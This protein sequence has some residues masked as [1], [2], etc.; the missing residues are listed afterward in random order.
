[1]HWET[2][3]TMG[4]A[5]SWWSDTKPTVSLRY[6][7]TC[8]HKL[9]EIWRGFLLVQNKV[10]SKNGIQHL[11]CME[12][13]RGR[14]HPEQWEWHHQALSWE[15]H[16]A[17][18]QATIALSCVCENLCFILIY[19]V[20]LL[21]GVLRLLLLCFMSFRLSKGFIGKFCFKIASA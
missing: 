3:N 11:F 2:K 4:L 9:K 10:K 21:A 15:L 18:H 5:L 13:L 17:S 16:S 20:H 14:G 19:S 8:F 12:L 6:A 7:R 1:M